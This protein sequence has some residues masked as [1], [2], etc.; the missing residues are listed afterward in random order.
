M[1]NKRLVAVTYPLSAEER[2][3]LERALKDVARV[4]Y[5]RSSS[6]Q[7]RLRTLEEA[8][9]LVSLSFS[10]KEVTLEQIDRLHRLRLI[11]LVFSGAD[12]VPFQRLP[13][14]VLVASNAGAFAEPL[15][16]HVLAMVLALAKRLHEKHDQLRR[17]VFDRSGE[18]VFLRGKVCGIIGL[19]GNGRAVAGLMRCLG[20][21]IYAVNRTGRTEEPV[22]FIGTPGD[23][24]RVLSESDVV[25]LTVPLTRQTR[26]LVGSRELGWMKEDA[27]LVNVARGAVID[28]EALYGHLRIHP[29]F[30]VGI[31]TW[32]AEPE[33]HGEFRLDYPLLELPNVLGT[34]HIADEVPGM[35][36]RAL[37]KALQNVKAFLSD[38]SLRG[39]LRREDYVDEG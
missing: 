28:P 16:E 26:G 18:S 6:P 13:Q 9:V 20:M 2:A 33:H 29:R 34:P 24:R 17:G 37:E 36:L 11:Q 1:G 35:R 19:G 23:L 38:Q 10:R 25:V 39:I 27:I 12:N 22:D 15:A 32:W 3:I 21:R 7:A 8:E 14:G 5:L 4:S 31:D 30:R